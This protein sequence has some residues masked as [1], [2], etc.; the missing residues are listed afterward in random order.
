LFKN[1]RALACYCGI[2]PFE[3]S[4]G[5]SNGTPKV[6]HLA[7]KRI[8]TMLNMAAV[9]AIRIKGEHKEYYNRRVK[10]GKSKMSTL[11]IIRNKLLYRVFAVVNRGTPYV[12]LY[13][14]AA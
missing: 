3:S 9:A 1:A 2:A 13:K 14:F 6:N 8:K 4:S 10:N 12:D 5:N 11:N 7:N